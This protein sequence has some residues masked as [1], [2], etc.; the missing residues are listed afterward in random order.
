M[1]TTSPWRETLSARESAF[2]PEK[3]LGGGDFITLAGL[4]HHSSRARA[5][6]RSEEDEN[7]SSCLQIV[8]PRFIR[9]ETKAVG[10]LISGLGCGHIDHMGV[11]VCF[12]SVFLLVD[13]GWMEEEGKELWRRER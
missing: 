2:H 5:L 9:I 4:S 11:F 1:L 10:V 3:Q 6:S 8:R 13:L 12:L 7:V